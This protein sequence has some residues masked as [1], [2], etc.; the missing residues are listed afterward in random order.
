[1][2]GKDQ[3]RGSPWDVPAPFRR[4][5]LS[6]V[7]LSEGGGCLSLFGLPFLAA[8]VFLTLAGAGVVPLQN[9]DE[10]P[11]WSWPLMV[12]MGLVFVAVG[13]TLVFGRRWTSFD[14][15][16]GRVIRRMGWL[17]PM[18]AE[19]RNLSEF[20]AVVVAFESG[21]S[22]SSDRYPVRLRAFA[23]KDFP[24]A[25]P[26]R[27]GEARVQA[28]FLSR[29]L[30]LPLVDASTGNEL[31]LAPERADET[32]QERLRA[33]DQGS[34]QV[35]R[36]EAMQC[37]VIEAG[38]ETTVVFPWR[39]SAVPS[40]LISVFAVVV[41]LLLIPNLLR[42]FRETG[43]PE[44]VQFGF[45]GFLTLLFGVLPLLGALNRA[46]AAK[47]SRTVIKVSPSGVTI[48]RRR[49]WRRQTSI[50]PAAEV[51]SIDYEAADVRLAAIRRTATT[52]QTAVPAPGSR[53]WRLIEALNRLVPSKGLVIKTRQDLLTVGEG[54]PADELRYL[55]ALLTRA[56]AG[57]KDVP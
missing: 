54:L 51:L 13:G 45:L 53:T 42:F 33:R 30:R 34:E 38:S 10:V 32:L 20:N 1:M 44:F 15:S 48:E 17:E 50:I 18:R 36:P 37:Q 55:A 6:Q 21:D 57:S 3:P 49:A 40:L 25:S 52:S 8:G 35:A 5:T 43:T 19:Q 24:V 31:V 14:L 28:E 4:V 9:A 56:L 41:L 22:D 23:G 16:Q 46:R 2:R 39:G 7:D 47:R 26:I 11:S 12:G 27:F 29:F